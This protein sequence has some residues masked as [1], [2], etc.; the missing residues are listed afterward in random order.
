MSKHPDE[1]LRELTALGLN[2]CLRKLRQWLPEGSAED[3]AEDI[4]HDVL[5]DS[6]R[7]HPSAQNIANELN[8]AT[9]YAGLQRG[10]YRELEHI[11]RSLQLNDER[12]DQLVMS[13]L[14]G[15]AHDLETSTESLSNDGDACGGSDDDDDQALTEAWRREFSTRYQRAAL[16]AR[17][18]LIKQRPWVRKAIIRK[19]IGGHDQKR[20]AHDLTAKFGR[21]ITHE[22]V[23]TA[24]SR[25]ED[26]LRVYLG[27][28]AGQIEVKVRRK[29][30]GRPNRSNDNDNDRQ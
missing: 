6:F 1:A 9:F 29:R 22:A 11:K 20:I 16:L 13:A 25:F 7:A 4:V 2:Y 28:L 21:K 24:M 27:D 5:L 23:R 8:A 3:A 14:V 10:V 30:G 18:L 12:E 26:R 15:D 17:Q 19:Y